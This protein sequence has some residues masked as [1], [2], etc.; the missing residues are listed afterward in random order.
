MSDV[1]T[2]QEPANGNLLIII[3][4]YYASFSVAIAL[5]F[6][7]SNKESLSSLQLFIF[8]KCNYNVFMFVCCTKNT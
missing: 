4:E 8:L 6:K 5:S 1:I 2:F 3:P 7:N